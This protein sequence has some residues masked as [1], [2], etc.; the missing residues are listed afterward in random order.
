MYCF[1]QITIMFFILFIVDRPKMKDLYNSKVVEKLSAACK[2]RRNVWRHLG[3][4]L[5]LS[6]SQ[7]DIIQVNHESCVES[8]CSAMLELWLDQTDAS[9]ERLRE[10]LEAVELYNLASIV[11]SCLIPAEICS[12][13]TVDDKTGKL[14]LT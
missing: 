4:E 2:K 1:N 12:S 5:C 8:R 9:W 13:N 7:L 6:R 3:Y 10:A 11:S 14:I